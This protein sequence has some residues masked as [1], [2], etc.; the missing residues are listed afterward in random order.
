[1]NKIR[2]FE[3]TDAYEIIH[4][5]GICG[6]GCPE[7]S[8]KAVHDMLKRASEPNGQVV[9]FDDCYIE[10]MCYTLND[11][12]FLEHNSSIYRS[13]LT[14]KGKTLLRALDEFEKLEYEWEN[15]HDTAPNYFYEEVTNE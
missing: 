15:V 2:V 9:P 10:F 12:G 1:M 6:C 14:D 7:G 3:P 11:K 13:F 5:L 8:Y 4:E